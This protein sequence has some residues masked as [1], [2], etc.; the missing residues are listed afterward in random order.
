MTGS[1]NGA[2]NYVA[3]THFNDTFVGGNSAINEY[4]YIGRN[5]LS[6]PAPTDSFTGGNFSQNFAIFP[7]AI[8]NYTISPVQA[9]GSVTVTAKASDPLRAG[10]LTITGTRYRPVFLCRACQALAFAPLRDPADSDGVLVA[11]AGAL[12][13]TGPINFPL[14]IDSGATLEFAAANNGANGNVVSSTF[15]DTGGTL[16]LDAV[17]QNTP[18]ASQ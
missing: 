7:D 8:S 18:R 2:Q 14:A 10:S 16:K 12:Y 17:A 1:S 13:I 6:G 5:S 15:L 3:G 11:S 4:Y 9:D